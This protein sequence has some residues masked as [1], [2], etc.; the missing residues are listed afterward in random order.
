MYSSLHIWHVLLYPLILQKKSHIQNG[1]F[2]ISSAI[3]L[4]SLKDNFCS[5]FLPSALIGAFKSALPRILGK[6]ATTSADTMKG[7]LGPF[8][9]FPGSHFTFPKDIPTKNANLWKK[10]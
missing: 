3:S 1:C 9:F 10:T 7:F 6:S 4:S 8:I 2:W 5:F